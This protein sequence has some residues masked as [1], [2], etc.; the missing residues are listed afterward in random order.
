[1]YKLIIFLIVL[2]INCFAQETGESGGEQADTSDVSNYFLFEIIDSFTP[3]DFAVYRD[4]IKDGL[5]DNYFALRMAY[6]KTPEYAPYSDMPGIVLEKADSLIGAGE[7]NKALEEINAIIDNYFASIKVH[8]YTGYIYDKLGDTVKSSLHYNIY[9]GLLESILNTGN[10]NTPETAYIV[11][12][13]REEYSFL[14]WFDL[15][16]GGQELIGKEGHS[17]DLLKTT[18]KESGEKFDIYFNIDV[19]MQYLNREFSKTK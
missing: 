13:T 15:S 2:G 5:S 14:N 12:D 10:G 1:M 3:G 8:M 6:A 9:R 19:P 7:F 4:S 18:E 17:F 16:S 11:I